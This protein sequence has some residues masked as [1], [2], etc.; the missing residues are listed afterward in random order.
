MAQFS[1]IVIAAALSSALSAIVTYFIVSQLIWDSWREEVEYQLGFIQIESVGDSMKAEMQVLNAIAIASAVENEEL[2]GLLATACTG[3]TFS[4]PNIK[5]NLYKESPGKKEEIEKLISE[6]RS[7]LNKLR[8]E[9][10]C[11]TRP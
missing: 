6:G 2:E 4:L 7:L 11:L 9:G 5:P 1:Q 10:V 3:L 8:Q